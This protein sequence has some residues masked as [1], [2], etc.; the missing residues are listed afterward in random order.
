MKSFNSTNSTLLLYALF[1]RLLH[2]FYTCLEFIKLYSNEL[3]KCLC[4]KKD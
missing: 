4:T 2:V 3:K 1:V